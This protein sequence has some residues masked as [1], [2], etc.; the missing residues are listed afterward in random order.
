MALKFIDLFAGIGGIRIALENVGMKCV[1]SSE[2]DGACQETY[3]ANFGERPYGDITKLNPNEIPDHDVLTGGF[4]CQPFSIIGSGKGFTDTRGTLFFDIEKILKIKKPRAFILENVKMLRG[5]DQGRTLKTIL[6]HLNDLGYRVEWKILNGLDFG[7]PQKRE[8]IL[9]VGFLENV[10]FDFPDT[11]S[12]KKTLL[13]EILEPDSEVDKKHFLSETARIK[14]NSKVIRDFP[15]PSVWHENKSGNI[16]VHEFSCALRANASHNYLVVNGKRRLTPREM[17][18]LQGFPDTFKIVVSDSQMRKQAGN[19][20]VVPKIQAVGES[21]KKALEQYD[22]IE[23]SLVTR[24]KVR[25]KLYD[26]I[27]KALPL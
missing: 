27:Q 16:G 9:L 7:V 15:V 10:N 5:H 11:T 6:D 2:W 21:V 4:P 3:F 26:S 13:A 24:S 18:R 17:L 8:R 1:F 12:I 22:L 19:S 25:T 20:V 14:I 23:T